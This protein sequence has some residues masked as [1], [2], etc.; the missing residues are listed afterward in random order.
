M[1]KKIEAIVVVFDKSN[2]GKTS[3]LRELV[4]VL[5]GSLPISK[6]D[7]RAI[8]PDYHAKGQHKKVNIYIA[9]CGDVPEIIDDNLRFFNGKMPD[10]KN[11]PTYLYNKG[12]WVEIKNGN[13]LPDIEA[14]VCI[15][16]CRSDGGGVDA[17]QYFIHSNLAY[18]FTCLWIRL[19]L[20]RQKLN[21]HITKKKTPNWT[22]V[23][24][25][26]KNMI[27]N[28]LARRFI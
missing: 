8:I 6:G 14:N 16:A 17:M 20:L 25:E 1:K 7:F 3:T 10:G 12:S 22:K 24:N 21:V 11:Y 27:D 23:A 26:L 9:T 15:S 28:K 18:S 19:S 5:T 4:N 2:Q 13:E